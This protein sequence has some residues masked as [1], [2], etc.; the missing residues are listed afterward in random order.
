MSHTRRQKYCNRK[1]NY[2]K[3]KNTTNIV[4]FSNVQLATSGS[5][6]ITRFHNCIL[7]KYARPFVRIIFLPTNYALL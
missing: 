7:M 3:T 5:K 2:H 1:K 4:N 6:D